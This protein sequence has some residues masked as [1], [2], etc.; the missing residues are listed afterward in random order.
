MNKGLK[1][2]LAASVALNIFAVVGGGT[3]WVL[4]R[5][6]ENQAIE[7]RRPGRSEPVWAVVEALPPAVRDQVR[8]ELRAN[9][10]EARP[11]F[12]DSR[13]AR[14]EAIAM[15][16]SDR[17][18]AVTVA[19]L[20]ERS[21]ASEMRGRARLEAG[22]VET[23]GRL[24][25]ENRKALAPILSRHKTKTRDTSAMPHPEHKTADNAGAPTDNQAAR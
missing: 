6:A 19:A 12:E 14:R 22:A 15:T 9:A 20:L 5:K 1:I 7:G 13:A 18:D 24:S 3:A 17:F 8:S 25:P 4:S 16:A 11:D 2:A 10:L 21:R 23:L